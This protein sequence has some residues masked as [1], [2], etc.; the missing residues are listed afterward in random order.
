VHTLNLALKNIC[1]PKE[2]GIASFT[3][4]ECIWIKYVMDD[5][6]F[7]KIFIMNHSMRLA[8]FNEFVPL[9]LLS[10]ADTRF[11]SSIIMMKRFKLISRDLQ[12][13]VISERWSSYREDDMGNHL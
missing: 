11:A 3:F 9:K 4:D 8:I 5:V 2:T 12:A 7:V 6:V 10:V 1:A 13:M